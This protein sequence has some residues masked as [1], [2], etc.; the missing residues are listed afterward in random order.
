MKPFI[1]HID[2]HNKFKKDTKPIQKQELIILPLVFDLD[3]E[4]PYFEKYFKSTRELSHSNHTK[5]LR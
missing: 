2:K 4:T 1:I 3:V 5:K